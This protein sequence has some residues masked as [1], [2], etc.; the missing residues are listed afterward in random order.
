MIACAG[1]VSLALAKILA[2]TSP[3]FEERAM[4]LTSGPKVS[5]CFVACIGLFPLSTIEPTHTLHAYSPSKIS[6]MQGFGV[7]PIA[8]KG[9]VRCQ[10]CPCL[11][12]ARLIR[13]V[14]W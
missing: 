12:H 9:P 3:V 6:V 13:K 8:Q 7:E 4:G 1:K 11:H 2:L 10:H 14:D 5:K